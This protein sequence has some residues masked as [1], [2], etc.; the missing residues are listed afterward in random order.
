[1]R[2]FEATS[3][4][5]MGDKVRMIIKDTGKPL[6]IPIRHIV[7]RKGELVCVEDWL[8]ARIA[9]YLTPAEGKANAK[10]N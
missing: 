5:P 8:Y 9:K 3:F 2:S 10:D 6:T 7:Y 1:M 4:E